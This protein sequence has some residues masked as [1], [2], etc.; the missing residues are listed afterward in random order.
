M[1]GEL[2]RLATLAGACKRCICVWVIGTETCR[3]VC[4]K[5][6]SLAMQAI[7]EFFHQRSPV[8]CVRMRRHLESKDFRGSVFVEFADEEAMQK[9][10]FPP[11]APF[12]H[13]GQLHANL[14]ALQDLAASA[15]IS[16]YVMRHLCFALAR[17]QGFIMFTSGPTITSHC[18]CQ[19]HGKH[20]VHWGALPSLTEF[21]VQV[22][23]EQLEYE[24]APLQL[25]PKVDYMARKKAERKEKAQ[26]C[27]CLRTCQA[28]LASI[29]V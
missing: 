28:V 8:N 27:L 13:I 15:D 25:E 10:Q 2:A 12:A 11:D 19:A 1:L 18:S 26:V 14:C 22:L 17:Q 4:L 3:E 5:P 24:G 7:T 6:F 23:K 9:V 20:C 16:S 29:V 21:S